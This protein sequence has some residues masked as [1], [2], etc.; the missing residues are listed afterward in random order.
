MIARY[1]IVRAA[2]VIATCLV[3]MGLVAAITAQSR[4]SFMPLGT[5]SGCCSQAHRIND[6]HLGDVYF[7][8]GYPF[9]DSSTG[10]NIDGR[11]EGAS[12]ALGIADRS[13][14]IV[15]GHGPVSDRLALLKY[16]DMPVI[17]RDRVKKLK[18]SSR[19][20]DEV[21]AE[22]PTGDLDAAWPAFMSPAFFIGAV[23]TTV[24]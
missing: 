24:A 12:S 4:Y 5:L 10:V 3:T 14:R 20:L 2:R 1:I 17:V 21:I 19:T 18:A 9:I 11:I 6:L 8:R 16:R 7:N 15:P 23:Y 22:R 13:T